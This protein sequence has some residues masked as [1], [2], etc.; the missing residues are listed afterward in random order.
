MLVACKKEPLTPSV[1][2]P[3]VIK[4]H[5]YSAYIYPNRSSNSAGDTLIIKLNGVV[6]ANKVGAAITDLSFNCKAGDDLSVYYNPGM[7]LYGNGYIVQENKFS[8]FLNDSLGNGY[9][10]NF[11]GCRC[12]GNYNQKIK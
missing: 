3:V 11:G 2:P 5:K 8:L 10:V 12:I 6:K 7:V 4:E 1:N 9:S